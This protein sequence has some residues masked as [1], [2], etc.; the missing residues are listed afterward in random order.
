MAKAT[1]SAKKSK[2]AQELGRKGG[3]AAVKKKAGIHS[4]KYKAKLKAKSKV[5][6][7]SMPKK[8]KTTKKK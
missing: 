8:R 3:K 1:K 5:K 2:C 6:K 4:P 7:T